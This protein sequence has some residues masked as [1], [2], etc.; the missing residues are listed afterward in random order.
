MVSFK[1]RMGRIRVSTYNAVSAELNNIRMIATRA[2]R[3]A[4]I[5]T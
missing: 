1:V 2:A 3:L 4:T 5:D